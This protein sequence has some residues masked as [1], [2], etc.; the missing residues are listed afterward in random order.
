[1]AAQLK[2]KPVR[3]IAGRFPIS[4]LLCLTS[5]LVLACAQATTR[6]STLCPQVEPI[7]SGYFLPPSLEWSGELDQLVGEYQFTVSRTLGGSESLRGDLFLRPLEGRALQADYEHAVLWGYVES[8]DS[9]PV[10][11]VGRP[12]SSRDPSKPGLVA[13]YDAR[14][15]LSLDLGR[16]PPESHTGMLLYVTDIS[17]SGLRGRWFDSAATQVIDPE[18][19]RKLGWSQG[20]F[21]ATKKPPNK[22]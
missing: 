6:R 13:S 1:V 9:L 14:Q 3:R 17:S 2:R 18:S 5:C 12:I 21:C 15:R 20:Y 11:R 19:G 7:T 4:R 22:R 16:G 10:T 8:A